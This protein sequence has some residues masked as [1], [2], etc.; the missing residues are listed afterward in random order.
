MKSHGGQSWRGN[1]C[2]T[3]K[4][5]IALGSDEMSHCSRDQA[6]EH[7]AGCIRRLGTRQAGGEVR[8]LVPEMLSGELRTRMEL[9][10]EAS[11]CWQR[12][13]VASQSAAVRSCQCQQLAGGVAVVPPVTY[14]GPLTLSKTDADRIGADSLGCLQSSQLPLSIL[15]F[16]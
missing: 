6:H 11:S 4:R 16:W 15:Y 3:V 12:L 5:G 14:S 2:N 10:S 13:S 7:R 8:W 9:V 1:G